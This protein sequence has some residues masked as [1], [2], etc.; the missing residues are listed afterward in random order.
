MNSV[1]TVTLDCMTFRASSPSRSGVDRK[2]A[3]ETQA[4]NCHRE[5][6]ESASLNNLKELEEHCLPLEGLGID[7][8]FFSY[9]EITNFP[10]R[11]TFEAEDFLD[12]LFEFKNLKH[13]RIK[14]PQSRS[15][16]ISS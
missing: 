6:T 14:R 8:S 2:D 4:I 13:P 3:Q 15:I 9:R 1:E 10:G 5:G 16:C 12:L 7:F 11:L